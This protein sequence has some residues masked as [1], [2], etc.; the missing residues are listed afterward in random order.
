MKVSFSLSLAFLENTNKKQERYLRKVF[1]FIS[2]TRSFVVVEA[3]HDDEWMKGDSLVE[4]VL[5]RVH[6]MTSVVLCN[7]VSFV[8]IVKRSFFFVPKK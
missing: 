2:R 3:K 8:L 7:H 5:K 6:L 4:S 1:Q